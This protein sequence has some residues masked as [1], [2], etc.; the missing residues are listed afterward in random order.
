D[1]RL[2]HGCGSLRKSAG[3]LARL[4][5]AVKRDLCRAAALAGPLAVLWRDFHRQR[6]ADCRDCDMSATAP[7]LGSVRAGGDAPPTRVLQQM[8]T[9]APGTA[10]SGA[11]APARLRVGRTPLMADEVAALFPDFLIEHG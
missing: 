4:T 5:G 1:R 9:L 6:S 7:R 11:A 10:A 2:C 3:H 8:E